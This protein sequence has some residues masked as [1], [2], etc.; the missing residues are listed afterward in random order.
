[1]TSRI[2]GNEAKPLIPAGSVFPIRGAWGARVDTYVFN[3]AMLARV[4]HHTKS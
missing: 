4:A 2:V 3:M 1:V